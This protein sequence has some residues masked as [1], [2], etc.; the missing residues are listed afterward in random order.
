[1]PTFGRTGTGA[2]HVVGPDG[3]RY[4][5]AFA[6]DPD[7]SPD[8]TVTETDIVAYE[9]P[10][11]DDERGPSSVSVS[12][13]LGGSTYARGRTDDQRFVLPAAVSGSESGLCG[14][15]RSNLESHQRRRSR[16][17]H[18]LKQ[19]T[20]VRD[21]DW[22]VTERDDDRACDWCGAREETTWH[23]DAL[24]C[25]VCPACGRLFGTPLGDPG[26]EHEPERDRLPPT[27]D[28]P[29]EPVVFG[30]SFPGYDP[31]DLIGSNRPLIKYRE[32]TKY[33]DVV[34]ELERTGHAFDADG[35]AALDRVRADYADRVA[36]DDAHRT[37]VALD[38]GQTPRTVSIE[39]IFPDDRETVVEECRAVVSDPDYW[40][41]V[42]WPD[43]GRIHAR[44]AEAAIPGSDRVVDAFPRLETQAPAESVDAGA[45]RSVTDP[46]RYERG[47]R[48][49]ER[50]AVTDVE[51]VDDRLQATVQGSRPYD[52][53]ATVRDGRF[54]EGECS[55]PDDAPVCKH[56]VAAVLASGDVETG[57]GGSDRSL[58]DVLEGASAGELRE[59]L[60]E[61]ADEDVSLRK[62][63]YEELDR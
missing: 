59:L 37:E 5:R 29:V 39:G 52:V 16:L 14:T 7:S 15:C 45:L 26:E 33:A 53:H 6:D 38:V 41:P 43:R 8:E 50:G 44:S 11:S 17:V 2:W 46:G 35:T 18:G 54:V 56:V 24:R 40:F 10:D 9:P 22:T 21:P 25:T 23:S 31:T 1:M 63:V 4:G 49:Y 48:Y 58:E 20:T 30:T 28:G 57:C 61:F 3:C 19:V 27:P 12:L 62:R 34:C 51:V 60:R 47:E 13:S 36:D 55:C 32:K 42:G